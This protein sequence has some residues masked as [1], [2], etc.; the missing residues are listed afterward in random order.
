MNVNPL[1]PQVVQADSLVQ[2]DEDALKTTLENMFVKDN[3]YNVLHY[4]EF[5]NLGL[6]FIDNMPV[7]NNKDFFDPTDSINGALIFN[8]STN[9]YSINSIDINSAFR[10]NQPGFEIQNGKSLLKNLKFTISAVAKI[11]NGGS[12]PLTSGNPYSD[13]VITTDIRLSGGDIE[14]TYHITGDNGFEVDAVGTM[15]YD[16]SPIN[17]NKRNSDYYD[18]VDPKKLIELSKKPDVLA[19][20]YD[21]DKMTPYTDG[22]QKLYDDSDKEV[23]ENSPIKQGMYTQYITINFKKLFEQEVHNGYE[24]LISHGNLKVGGNNIYDYRNTTNPH[25]DATNGTLTYTRTFNVINDQQEIKPVE[26]ACVENPVKIDEGTTKTGLQNTIKDKLKVEKGTTVKDIKDVV[27]FGKLF[28]GDKEY[29]SDKLTADN[30]YEQEVELNLKDLLGS[31]YMDAVNDNKVTINGKP[32]TSSD[33]KGDV[34]TFKQKVEAN[35]LVPSKPVFN[36]QPDTNYKKFDDIDEGTPVSDFNKIGLLRIKGENDDETSVLTAKGNVKFGAI[37]DD[38]DKYYQGIYLQPGTYH[39]Q[40][41]IHVGKILDN[42]YSAFQLDKKPVTPDGKGDYTYTRDITVNQL[43]SISISTISAINDDKDIESKI[44]ESI[45]GLKGKT[46]WDQ[47]LQNNTS[48]KDSGKKDHQDGNPIYT[49]TIDLHALLGN[50]KYDKF[51]N[52]HKIS[53]NKDNQTTPVSLDSDGNYTYQVTVKKAS[54]GNSNKPSQPGSKPSTPSQPTQ[55]TQPVNPSPAP[56]PTAPAVVTP[57]QPTP[58]NKPAV[59]DEDLNGV[60]TI[61]NGSSFQYAQIFDDNGNVVVD[62]YL[63][64]NS[65]WKTDRRRLINGTYYY[66]VSTHEYVRLDQVIYTDTPTKST[67]IDT[68]ITRSDMAANVFQVTEPQAYLWEISADGQRLNQKPDR[69]LVTGSSWK[70]GQKLVIDGATFY[71]VSTNEWV[72]ETK[73]Y[74]VK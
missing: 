52:A 63:A 64:L 15:S 39:Q 51:I 26:V 58:D 48:I 3:K 57:T 33:I 55:P 13:S 45:T 16:N 14:L 28:K 10:P 62:R 30:Y 71:Q 34:Y 12:Y 38:N 44:K 42:N 74:L 20:G 35:A 69:L 70:T 56:Q 61:L 25:F 6:N 36:A 7:A 27:K 40:V 22:L 1:Q 37:K 73:G 66:R 18:D 59:T 32:V 2:D 50:S 60:V 31:N 5:K 72:K 21:V 8:S 17:F 67:W 47:S 46:N 43:D 9:K 29:T 11:H 53:I 41:T 49:V 4:N 19:N 24:I 54:G 65:A 23:D 68:G